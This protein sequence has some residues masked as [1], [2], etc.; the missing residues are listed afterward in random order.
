[1]ARVLRL[2]LTILVLEALGLPALAEDSAGRQP[3]K[4][5]A[6]LVQAEGQPKVDAETLQV[7]LERELLDN[8]S[9]TLL[10]RKAVQA[11]LREMELNKANAAA[12]QLQ[13]GKVLNV[14]YLLLV[15]ALD[16]ST[17]LVVDKFPS[18]AVLQEASFS[19]EQDVAA[20]AKRI[21]LG[22]LRA[23]DKDALDENS[24]YV[25]IGSLYYE[26]PFRR[27]EVLDPSVHDLLRKRL[28][29]RQGFVVNERRFPSHLLNEFQLARSGVATGVLANLSAPP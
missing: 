4:R 17:A 18:G 19:D 14:D 27:Y 21:T 5:L 7:L 9:G 23:I 10:E 15:R 26:D 12:D 22:A 29:G 20:L 13:L 3:S 6:V 2:L 16:K 1:M 8:W 11:I 28:A 24:L 25:S